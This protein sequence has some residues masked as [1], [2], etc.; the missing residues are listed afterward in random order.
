MEGRSRVCM[1]VCVCGGGVT[2]DTLQT[3]KNAIAPEP[4]CT[5]P[6]QSFSCPG[7]SW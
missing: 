7:S 3:V 4:T 5:R 1:C 6:I 2:I